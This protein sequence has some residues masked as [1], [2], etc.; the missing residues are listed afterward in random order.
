ME[1]TTLPPMTTTS[2]TTMDHAL[3]DD[4]RLRILSL[5]KST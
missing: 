1:D 4:G 2:T 3:R 5:A